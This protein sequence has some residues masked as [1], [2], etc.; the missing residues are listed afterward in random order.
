MAAM[1]VV[2]E[3]AGALAG[4]LA[5]A[6]ALGVAELTA[7]VTGARGAPVVAVGEA[8]INLTPVPV[9]EFAITHFGTHDKL[10]LVTG[11][12]CCWPGSPRS[13]GCWRC[14]GWPSGWPGSGRSP[15]SAWPP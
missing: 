12:W 5:G 15:R 2:R 3:A 9:K 13:S 10:A 7:A 4:L 11:S 8:A 1:N 14:G 6:V